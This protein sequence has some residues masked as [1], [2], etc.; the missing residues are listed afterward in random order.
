[1][2]KRNFG[3]LISKDYN[4]LMHGIIK[5]ISSNAD[6]K[7]LIPVIILSLVAIAIWYISPFIIIANT[8]P[9][10]Q[11][12]KRLYTILGACLTWFLITTFFDNKTHSNASPISGSNNPELAKKRRL[13]ETRFRSAMHF[14]KN[15]LMTHHQAEMNLNHLPWY[16]MIG[17]PHSGKTTLLAN[18]NIHYVLARKFKHDNIRTI[19]ATEVCDWW[20]TRDAVLVDVPGIYINSRLKN[21]ANADD[22]P[23]HK[24]SPHNVLWNSLLTLLKKYRGKQA[25]DGVI[26]ALPLPELIAQQHHGKERIL[27]ELKQRSAE[28][29]KTFGSHLPFYIIITKCD[30]LPGFL[31]FFGD[32]G[33]DELSQAWGITMPATYEKQNFADIF[34]KRFNTLIQRLN[35]Q[36][37]WRLH[38]ERNPAIRPQIKDFPLHIERLKN[39]ILNAL[40]TL[41]IAET[42]LQVQGVYLTSGI[43][44]Y[45]E[46]KTMN[47]Y[48]ASTAMQTAQFT[49]HPVTHRHKAFFIRQL[50]LKGLAVTTPHTPQKL[51]FHWK[52]RPFFYSF[53]ASIIFIVSGFICNQLYQH[54]QEGRAI[55]RE[56]LH[57]KTLA[58][59]AN[60][61]HSELTNALPLLQALQR[62]ANHYS[63]LSLSPSSHTQAVAAY[64]QALQKIVLPEIKKAFA[65][66][67]IKT[68]NK[69]TSELYA[70][71]TAYLMLGDED[72]YS[73]ETVLTTLKQISPELFTDNH[74]SG[75]TEQIQAALKT[76]SWQA[77]RLNPD[78]ITHTRQ[79]LLNLMPVEI[80]YAI[81]KSHL[82]NS[83]LQ[84]NTNDKNM[85]TNHI[86]AMFTITTFDRIYNQDIP[87]AVSELVTSNWVLG[88]SDLTLDT[89]ALTTELRARYTNNYTA[90]WENILSNITTTTPKTLVETDFRIADMASSHSSLLTLLRTI[91]NNT[92]PAPIIAASPKLAEINTLFSSNSSEPSDKLTKIQLALNQLHTDLQHILQANN[93]AEAAF[94]A[95][96]TRMRNPANQDSINQLLAVANSSP[97][98]LNTLLVNLAV[99]SWHYV[100]QDAG[101]FIQQHWQNEVMSPYNTELANRF[102]FATNANE[103]VTLAQFGKFL[104][105]QGTLANFFKNYLQP[106]ADNSNKV[107][108]WKTINNERIPFTELALNQ[109]QHAANL[110][111][112]FFPNGDNQPLIRFTVQPVAL[113]SNTKGLQLNIDGEAIQYDRTTPP[114]PQALIWPNVNGAHTTIVNLLT[115]ND[116]ALNTVNNSEWGWFK[117]VNQFTQKVVTPKELV[118]S[119]EINGHKATC[120]LFSQSDLNPFLPMNLQNFRLSQQLIG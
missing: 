106:F 46:A 55:D 17:M 30:L 11:P 96:V 31:E 2:P 54:I 59:D 91:Q 111:R 98:P 48:E 22:Q 35:K 82:D 116:L 68:S 43:Q 58:H 109:L 9:F 49:Q 50:I 83:A 25:L 4:H 8:S 92:Q 16:L 65:N 110:Q 81:L 39:S 95:A 69:N 45:A 100:L 94:T 97:T 53:C 87:A 57:Y 101:Q 74:N 102:P 89:T 62:A 12:S 3:C 99:T 67:L 34:S 14:L 6:K 64:H 88:T 80:A 13:L 42:N 1:M 29:R 72:K 24:V 23:I 107:W 75:L 37:I 61:P 115:N 120:L 7:Q 73:A 36:L 113:A 90:A 114:I 79:K 27:L 108:T 5:Q 28:L 33:A 93:P 38:Q 117:L 85:A 70:S 60:S 52:D 103:E 119:F 118:L 47:V 51:R 40:N 76:Q 63:L 104:G 20:V 26:V 19:P 84:N 21:P 105:T 112:A 86:P 71:L 18:A 56:V 15:T 77:Q 44:Q 10:S 41:E 32:I 78:I 66:H